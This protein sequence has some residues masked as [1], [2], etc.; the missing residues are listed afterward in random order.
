MFDLENMSST[1]DG[2]NAQLGQEINYIGEPSCSGGHWHH[3][4]FVV[5]RIVQR[6]VSGNLYPDGLRAE[7]IRAVGGHEVILR[8]L[9]VVA[10]SVRLV[11][12]QIG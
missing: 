12:R 8:V 2:E 1:I 3:Y 4:Q 11:Y 9:F 5:L 10:V 6:P 7:D